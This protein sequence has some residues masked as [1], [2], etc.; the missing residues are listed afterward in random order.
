MSIR[1][2]KS[3]NGKLSFYVYVT[4]PDGAPVYVGKKATKEDARRLENDE[5]AR[6]QRM[7][8]AQL[9]GAELTVEEAWDRV[10][11]TLSERS[12]KTYLN[13]WKSYIAP[14]VGKVKL[15]ALSP[16]MVDTM[17]GKLLAEFSPGTAGLA[18]NVL[19]LVLGKCVEYKWIEENPVAGKGIKRG[20][21]RKPVDD[22]DQPAGALKFIPSKEAMAKVLRAAPA[23]APRDTIAFGMFTGCR[24]GEVCAVD[25]RDVHLKAGK[26]GICR[27]IRGP[28]KEA[29]DHKPLT[30]WMPIQ[31][32]LRPILERRW[33]AQGRP[34]RGRVFPE[35]WKRKQP[36]S[37]VR[38]WLN[39]ALEASGVGHYSTH[40]SFR[41]T[42]ASHFVMEGGDIF[43]L[44]KYLGHS[45]VKMT[46]SVYAHLRPGA[47]AEDESRIVLPPFEGEDAQV[48]PLRG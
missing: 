38:E 37:F 17:R 29:R 21:A 7:T 42:F 5:R 3:K 28:L 16:L 14:H 30:K 33:L 40:E 12:R 24:I 19:R 44:A 18:L 1:R 6:R 23:G 10:L 20:V 4:G 34:E 26:L 11:P 47:F 27:S 48:L 15:A 46:Y 8:P 25:W 2:H 43:R 41:H 22:D 31:T 13:T 9:D 32:Q 39:A 35:L 36:E 45:D